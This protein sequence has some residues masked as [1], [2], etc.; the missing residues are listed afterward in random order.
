MT[1]RKSFNAVSF[2]L[3]EDVDVNVQ[4]H[5]IVVQMVTGSVVER[6]EKRFQNRGD[7]YLL[8]FLIL[9]GPFHKPTS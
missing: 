5:G 4:P 9:S 7:T 6:T 1:V 2:S 3:L 8:S